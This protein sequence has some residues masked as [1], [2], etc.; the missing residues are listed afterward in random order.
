MM[1]KAN[2]AFLDALDAADL[3]MIAPHI[4]P[5]R[6]PLGKI[7]QD[8]EALVSTA[9]FP[10]GGVISLNSEC[11]TEA[12]MLGSNS[13]LGGWAALG[14]AS[15]SLGATVVSEGLGF[16]VPA[17]LLRLTAEQ[18]PS[19]RR[20]LVKHVHALETQIHA[21]LS[22]NLSHGIESRL[23][24]WLLNF[25]D[26]SGKREWRIT[27]AALA[28]FLGVQRSTLFIAAHHLKEEKILD[29]KH[30]NVQL[31]D[32]EKLQRA[33]CGCYWTTRRHQQRIFGQRVHSLT[34]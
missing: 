18:S 30:G 27:Q 13:L 22:C 5:V 25:H 14:S 29:Y 23:V 10:Q 26:V 8:A 7:L 17:A 4:R 20:L 15:T 34:A 33:A 32:L 31:L 12:G 3:A 11:H 2:N 19:L 24:R 16:T 21:I 28:G 6:L 1:G 9:Y